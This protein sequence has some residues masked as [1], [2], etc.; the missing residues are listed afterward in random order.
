MSTILNFLRRR[1]MSALF[2]GCGHFN[3]YLFVVSRLSIKKG[4][5]APS[6]LSFHAPGRWGQRIEGNHEIGNSE[7]LRVTLPCAAGMAAL[8]HLTN[9][10]RSSVV[11]AC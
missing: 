8:V 1:L 7:G 11:R 9:C 4:A 3:V 5:G 10:P 2:D 6:R